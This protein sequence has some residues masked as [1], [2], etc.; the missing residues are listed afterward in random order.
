VH[1]RMFRS[2]LALEL[3]FCLHK[4]RKVLAI[5]TA[6]VCE[7]QQDARC[8]EQQPRCREQQQD[9]VLRACCWKASPDEPCAG[10]VGIPSSVVGAA[11]S[12]VAGDVGPKLTLPPWQCHRLSPTSRWS[13]WKG[14]AY[15]LGPNLEPKWLRTSRPQNYTFK[16][17]W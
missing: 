4:L 17:T 1:P 11:T 5:A 13:S 12:S 10:D 16:A 2:N 14:A 7:Q 3:Q 9:A 15:Q 8:R 6:L